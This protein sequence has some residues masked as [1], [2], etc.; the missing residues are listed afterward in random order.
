MNTKSNYINIRDETSTN[1]GRAYI[2]KM[3]QTEAKVDV[4]IEAISINQHGSVNFAGYRKPD[5][6][7]AGSCYRYCLLVGNR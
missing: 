5:I 3:L 7:S 4:I 6:Q 2:F 1:Q